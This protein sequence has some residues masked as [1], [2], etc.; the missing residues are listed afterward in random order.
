MVTK[1][2]EPESDD[3]G[4]DDGDEAPDLEEK[5]RKVLGS[6]LGGAHVSD[7]SDQGEDGDEAKKGAKGARRGSQADVED[8]AEAKVR[9]VL[10][11]LKTEEEHAAEHARLKEAPKSESAPATVRRFTRWMWG[12]GE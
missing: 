9:A 4:V 8:D 12:S 7:T 11:K 2:T 6:L 5:V 3:S 1:K 10:H